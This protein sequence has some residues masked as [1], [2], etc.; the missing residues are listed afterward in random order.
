MSNRVIFNTIFSRTS[1]TLLM[2]KVYVVDYQRCSITQCGRPCITKCPV[3]ISARKKKKVEEKIEIPIRVKESTNQIIIHSEF[4]IKCGIC[5]NICPTKAIHV[6]ISLKKIEA[7]TCFTLTPR[8]VAKR[9]SGFM[10]SLRS[11]QAASLAF[12]GQMALENR[13]CSTSLEESSSQISVNTLK[14]VI[15]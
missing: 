12:A 1:F 15:R 8:K 9:A 10:A 2:K 4:C 13:R 6:K 14:N 5:A 3:S 7:R 11:L